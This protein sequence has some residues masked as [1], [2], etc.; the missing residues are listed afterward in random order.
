MKA[1]RIGLP[2]DEE[3]ILARTRWDE[4]KTDRTADESDW[5]A[6]ARFIRPQR[7]GF[8]GSD[9]SLRR[10]E[11]P[12]SSA[13]IMAAINFSSGLY[14][15]LTNPANRWMRLTMG[16][17]AGD[18]P[19]M[20]RWLDVVTD[21]IL[22]S[23]R[24][25]VSPFYSSVNQ[26]FADI[27][28]FGNAAQYDELREQKRRIVDVTLSLAEIVFEV[29]ADGEV[30]EVV[31][32]FELRPE[33]AIGLFGAEGLPTKILEQ[34]Q[35]KV[36]D[37][38]VY[39]HHVKLNLDLKTGRLGAD[40]K[41]WLSIYACEIEDTLVRRAGYDEMPFMAPRWEVESGQTYGTGPGFVALASARLHHRMEEANLRAGQKAADP[42]LLAPD[43]DAMPL[44]GRIVPGRVIYGGV[45]MRGN[46]LVRP[47]D[48]LGNTGL[49]LEMQERKVAEIRDVFHWTLMNLAGRTGMTATEVLQ[50]QEEKMR[51]MAPHLGRVQEE[52][53]AP[54]IRRR[55][56]L[57]WRA[58]QL[59]PPPEGSGGLPLEV[60]YTSAAAMA[61]KSADGA[62][63]TRLLADLAP[64]AQLK[65]RTMERIN[66]DDL[67][68]VLAE[69]RGTPSRV[70]LS[71]EE[72]DQRSQA[73]AEQ[74]QAAQAMQMA[75]AG[76]GAA[77]DAAQAA[78]AV[79]MEG[80]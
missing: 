20:R 10:A 75:Q 11:K 43:R 47:L 28:S 78:Q 26:L 76:A 24:P 44:N 15:T 1:S 17:G 32:R 56:A 37:R 48:N 57:L 50:I 58:G 27:T 7:R 12:L 3:A 34:A 31:R 4:L 51:L 61:Q 39:Y 41:R 25:A 69:A 62:N 2:H 72:A 54:K 21:R 30:V 9:P 29:D 67:V 80:A 18:S 19:E 65:P 6:I 49:T 63:V 73:R 33:Q 70:L 79:G 5:E 8:V 77:R 52:Y 66:E 45:D 64:L 68:E 14:G 22:A 16:G 36:R 23:F 42:T 74:E 71:R 38:T 59:P 13:P 40:G 35:K 55:F 60:E 53:L 46:A